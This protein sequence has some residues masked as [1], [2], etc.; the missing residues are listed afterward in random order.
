MRSIDPSELLPEETVLQKDPDNPFSGPGD[1]QE[2]YRTLYIAYARLQPV[3]QKEKIQAAPLV[4]Q[5]PRGP[6][7]L[8]RWWP[9]SMGM[10][11][12]RKSGNEWVVDDTVTFLTPDEQEKV[13]LDLARIVLNPPKWG[14]SALLMKLA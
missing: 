3:F 14:S 1:R 12:M 8:W 9:D 10:V 4:V 2:P 13:M 7:L 6:G 11:L 5:T